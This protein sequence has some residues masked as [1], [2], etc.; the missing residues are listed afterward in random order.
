MGVQEILQNTTN[1]RVLKRL[2]TPEATYVSLS[3]DNPE[4]KEDHA[5]DGHSQGPQALADV[6]E[7]IRRFWQTLD[8]KGG[9]LA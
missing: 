5:L 9:L 7:A 4:L 8:F 3:F 1:L 2:M 6:F